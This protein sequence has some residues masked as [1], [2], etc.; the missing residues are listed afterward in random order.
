MARK[1][2]KDGRSKNPWHH[3][4]FDP[5]RQQQILAKLGSRAAASVAR[6]AG[7]FLGAPHASKPNEEESQDGK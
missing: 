6:A 3:T 2:T 4:A 1:P 5:A 7:S